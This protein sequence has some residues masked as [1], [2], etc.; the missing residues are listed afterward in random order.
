MRM[1]FDANNVLFVKV[2]VKKNLDSKF[3]AITA[4][5][6][7]S[8]N[9]KNALYFATLSAAST[10]VDLTKAVLVLQNASNTE[11]VKLILTKQVEKLLDK[12]AELAF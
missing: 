10:I 2:A 7:E 12:N 1:T 3:L 11:L 5:N 6:Y 4:D 9:A 8:F